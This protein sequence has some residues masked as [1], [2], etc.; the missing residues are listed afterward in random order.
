MQDTWRNIRDWLKRIRL[1][2]LLTG[3]KTVRQ[4]AEPSFF[5]YSPAR[6]MR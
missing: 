2:Q 3:K 1:A 4:L 5:R 6:E